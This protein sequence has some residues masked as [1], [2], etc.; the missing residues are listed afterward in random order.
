[1][2]KFLGVVLFVIIHFAMRSFKRVF[3]EYDN[4]N[5]SLQEN[6][7]GIRV[8][9]SFVRENFEI[10]KFNKA[11]ERLYKLFCKAET[12][13]C[14]NSPFMLLTVYGCILALSWFGA[15]EVIDGSLS[16]G[17]LTGLLTYVVNIMLSLMM[18]SMAFVTITLST[19]R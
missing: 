15:H 18:L 19:A 12:I 8:V 4:F 16:T 9:K 17:Q 7:R 1:M 14:I 6:I 3:N 10:H 11:I 13:T 5:A 2:A